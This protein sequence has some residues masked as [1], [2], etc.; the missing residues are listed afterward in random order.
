MNHVVLILT[1]VS[2]DAQQLQQCLAEARDGPFDVV[3]TGTLA[4]ALDTITTTHIDAALADLC[5]PDSQGLATFDRLAKA[6]P[7]VPILTLSSTNDETDALPPSSA[8]PMAS[9]PRATS[10]M[11][12]CRRR[13]AA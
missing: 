1:A 6:L 5:L 4:Q 3:V 13:C 9:C 11:R 7:T 12:W 2:A 8:A 10:A